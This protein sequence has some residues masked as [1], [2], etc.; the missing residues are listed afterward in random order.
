[1]G[2]SSQNKAKCRTP[3]PYPYKIGLMIVFKAQ[4]ANSNRNNLIFHSSKTYVNQLF[5]KLRNP[6]IFQY[7]MMHIYETADCYICFQFS[8]AVNP[9]L[10]LFCIPNGEQ[11]I[12]PV[13]NMCQLNSDMADHEYLNSLPTLH[14]FNTL[15]Q[16]H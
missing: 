7:I 9:K 4:L 6:N 12:E 16:F 11:I 14:Q 2:R 13:V 8:C 15:P 1:M 10:N 5:V 3:Q